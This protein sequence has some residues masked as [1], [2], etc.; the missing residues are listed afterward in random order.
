MNHLS[1]LIVAVRMGMRQGGEIGVI[2]SAMLVW[3]GHSC[4]TLL[5]SLTQK[6]SQRRRTGVSDPQGPWLIWRLLRSITQSFGNDMQL[7]VE[8]HRS[9]EHVASPHTRIAET[10]VV[11][12]HDRVLA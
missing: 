1:A 10:Q 8:F 12:I 2:G 9:R 7:V 3:V 11:E 5:T 4:P 6:Q